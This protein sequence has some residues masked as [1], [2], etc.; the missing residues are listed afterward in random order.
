M[1]M[2]VMFLSVTVGILST[3]AFFLTHAQAFI[4]I[5]PDSSHVQVLIARA[6]TADKHSKPDVPSV[7]AVDMSCVL[8]RV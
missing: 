4:A 2:S 6:C 3:V 7:L 8:L 5:S 1:Y